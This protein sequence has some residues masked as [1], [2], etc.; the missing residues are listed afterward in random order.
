MPMDDVPN[1]LV[2]GL[3]DNSVVMVESVLDFPPAARSP[4]EDPSVKAEG[5]SSDQVKS[6]SLTERYH[7]LKDALIRVHVSDQL[8]KIEPRPVLNLMIDKNS[9]LED[10]KRKALLMIPSYTGGM[11]NCRFRR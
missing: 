10:L 6:T 11:Q 8:S 4:L 5:G 9:P 3:E 2:Y 7:V 1:L